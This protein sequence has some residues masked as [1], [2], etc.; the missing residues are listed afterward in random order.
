M[1]TFVVL[2]YTPREIC[3]GETLLET[4]SLFFLGNMHPQFDEYLTVVTE[5]ALKFVN[6][7]VSFPPFAFLYQLVASSFEHSAIP[8]MVKEC[9][10]SVVRQIQ[11]IAMQ[12]VI[13]LLKRRGSRAWINSKQA[14]IKLLRDLA[15]EVPFTCGVPAFDADDD[16]N[17]R[18]LRGVLKVAQPLLQLRQGFLICRL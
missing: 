10:L 14:W 6:L 3:I 17:I 5:P 12:K 11:L 18:G 7:L 1:M 15:N 16:R 8:A 13:S 4:L 9:H 2:S